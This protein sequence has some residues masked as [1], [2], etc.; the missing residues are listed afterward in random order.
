[1]A[2][3]LKKR[4]LRLHGWVYHIGLGLVKCYDAGLESFV[5]LEEG[6]EGGVVSAPAR[7]SDRRRRAR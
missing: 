3:G 7:V 2:D 5:P 4:S 1:M 6:A